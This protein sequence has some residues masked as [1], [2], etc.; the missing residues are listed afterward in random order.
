MPQLNYLCRDSLKFTVWVTISKFVVNGLFLLEDENVQSA[1]VCQS[2]CG[3]LN[4]TWLWGSCLGSQVFLS[5]QSLS[6]TSN[7]SLEWLQQRFLDQL[8]YR[9]QM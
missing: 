2:V 8:I 9:P 4:S 1:T 5:Q 6:R 7:K 3:V